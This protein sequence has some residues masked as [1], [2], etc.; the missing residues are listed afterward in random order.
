MAGR[1]VVQRFTEKQFGERFP[2]ILACKIL[3][4][5]TPTQVISKMYQQKVKESTFYSREKSHSREKN[6]LVSNIESQTFVFEL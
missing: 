6:I 5:D 1:S 4:T 2:E 3:G